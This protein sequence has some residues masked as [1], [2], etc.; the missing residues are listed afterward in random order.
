MAESMIQTLEGRVLFAATPVKPSKPI[1]F[2]LH[3]YNASL[4]GE[5]TSDTP[6]QVVGGDE[7]KLSLKLT[8]RKK[9]RQYG[10]IDVSFVLVKG[11][12]SPSKFSPLLGQVTKY[13]VDLGYKQ[14]V[15]ITKNI[16]WSAGVASGDY[17]VAASVDPGGAVAQGNAFGTNV[18]GP[19]VYLQKAVTDLFISNFDVRSSTDKKTGRTVLSFVMTI[20]NSGTSTARGDLPVTVYA[21][22]FDQASPNDVPMKSTTL[23]KL[24]LPRKTSKTITMTVT[25]PD[26]LTPDFYYLRISLDTSQ[27]VG[28]T[29]AVTGNDTV[30]SRKSIVLN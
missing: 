15:T 6:F 11:T 10:T 20:L 4:V 22:N 29:E 25:V 7:G 19:T 12:A 5:F 3:V 27:L 2:P 30:F 16:I 21:A 18:A 26:T 1:A 8:N 9:T 13:V 14:S 23:K 28:G 17:T 24:V